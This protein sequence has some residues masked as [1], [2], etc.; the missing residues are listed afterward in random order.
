MVERSRDD[1]VET[2]SQQGWIKKDERSSKFSFRRVSQQP[3]EEKV[4]IGRTHL[5]QM[6]D[7]HCASCFGFRS[8][9]ESRT[10]LTPL[11]RRI[12]GRRRL[13]AIRRQSATSRHQAQFRSSTCAGIAGRVRT[14][15]VCV[16]RYRRITDLVIPSRTEVGIPDYPEKFRRDFLIVESKTE[17]LR[18]SESQSHT[19]QFEFTEPLRI[20]KNHSPYR[21][22]RHS[23]GRDGGN[24]P[25]ASAQGSTDSLVKG[26]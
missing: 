1:P 7:R 2:Y 8:C 13:T 11:F 3:P 24:T 19:Q 10:M 14:H 6:G 26:L 15:S 17:R 9:P 4:P 20:R 22:P 5:S 18:E 25:E 23:C 21:L 16:S 12:G